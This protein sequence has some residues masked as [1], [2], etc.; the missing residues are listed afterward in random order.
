VLRHRLRHDEH[1]RQY[2][3]RLVADRVRPAGSVRFLAPFIVAAGLLILGAAVW[4]FWFNPDVS[5]LER[6]AA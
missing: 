4:A 5:V 1:G 2:R 6:K 3:R